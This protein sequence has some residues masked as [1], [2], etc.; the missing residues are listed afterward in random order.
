MIIK[1]L[2]SEQTGNSFESKKMKMEA[3]D[4]LTHTPPPPHL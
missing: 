3:P 2:K 1:D 4:H